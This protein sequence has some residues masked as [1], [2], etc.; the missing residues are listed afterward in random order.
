MIVRCLSITESPKTPG[1]YRFLILGPR[2]HT[3]MGLAVFSLRSLVFLCILRFRIFTVVFSTLKSR[4][5]LQLSNCSLLR[6][7]EGSLLRIDILSFW[8]PIWFIFE[9]V[10]W[11]LIRLIYTFLSLFCYS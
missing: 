7:H 8:L 3:Y 10:W 11:V 9:V 6:G 2:L 4:S 5:C 1:H